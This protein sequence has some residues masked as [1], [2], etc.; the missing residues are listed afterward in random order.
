VERKHKVSSKYGKKGEWK[1]C[2]GFDKLGYSVITIDN[3]SN[4]KVHRIIAY[5]FLGLDIDNSKLYIDHINHIT[6]D[7]RIEN[8]RIVTHQQ[9]QFNR[10]NV[11]GYYWNK[12]SRNWSSYIYLNKK[13]IYL[14]SFNTEEEAHQAYL[15]AK[16]K[17]HYI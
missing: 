9:N 12:I 7:N 4:V 6:N 5:C 11:K 8:L 16:E 17:Y 15:Q 3:I 1:I 2:G 14:G 10:S 13:L